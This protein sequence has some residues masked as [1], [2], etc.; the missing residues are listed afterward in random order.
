MFTCSSLESD[1]MEVSSM[2][3]EHSTKMV[4]DVI[5]KVISIDFA[6]FWN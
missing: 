1:D 6:W 3:I 2:Q 4:A 5:E